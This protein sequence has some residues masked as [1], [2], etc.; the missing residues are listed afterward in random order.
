MAASLLHLLCTL[1]KASTHL[2]VLVFNI[3]TGHCCLCSYFIYHWVCP[4][5]V[6]LSVSILLISCTYHILIINLRLQYEGTS[7]YLGK[8]VTGSKF[9]LWK[10]QQG[11]CIAEEN[12]WQGHWQICRQIMVIPLHM[13]SAFPT[14]MGEQMILMSFSDVII[15]QLMHLGIGYKRKV[16]KSLRAVIWVFGTEQLGQLLWG[17]WPSTLALLVPVME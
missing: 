4:Y 16:C 11:S 2:I 8:S 10:T 1:F 9:G 5:L 6:C 12:S 7:K 13:C 15:A 14:E 17:H 3:T